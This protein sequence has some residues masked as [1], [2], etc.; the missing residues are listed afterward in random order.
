MSTPYLDTGF[1]LKRYVPEPNSAEARAALLPY[2]P[3]LYL[4]D[5]LEMEMVNT[6]HMKVFRSEMTYSELDQCLAAFQTDIAEGFWQRTSI[7]PSSLRTRVIGIASEH[8]A[9]LGG[10][11]LDI[12]HIAC[13]LELG[14]K[15]FLSFDNRQRVT[16]LAQGLNV[17]P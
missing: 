10:R 15:D 4:T 13:A 1:A 2:G 9:I 14:C 16:A 17:V 12:L 5:I 8:T 11:T 7:D 6:F 3:P